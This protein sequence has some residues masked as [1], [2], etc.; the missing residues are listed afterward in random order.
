MSAT[1]IYA[2]SPV[3]QEAHFCEAREI[4]YGGTQGCGK[5]WFLRW[6][7]I[8]TQV[9]DWNGSPGEHT[10]YLEAIQRGEHYESKGWALHLRRTFPEIEQTIQKT[11]G[12]IRKFDPGADWIAKSYII[13]LSCGYRIQFGHCKEDDSW[14]AYDTNEYSHIAFDE[15]IHF[16]KEQYDGIRRRLRCEDQV[17]N[18]KRRLVSAS[19]PDA[20]AEGVWVKERFVDPAPDGRTLLRTEVDMFDGTKE[21]YLAM[22]IPASL[23]DNPDP[24]FRKQTEIDLR[25]QPFHVQQ[26]RLLG[27]WGVVEGAFFSHIWAPSVH[28][29]KPF[30]C[31]EHNLMTC[32][33][34]RMES[35]VPLSYPRGR[36][37][38]YGYKKACPVM[39]YAKNPDDDIIVYRE[40]T[41]NHKVPENK[42]KDAQM[43]ALAIKKIEQEHGEWDEKR[44]CSKL[45][46]PADYQIS[47]DQGGAGL[48]VE[49]TM[50]R[51]GVYW[52]KSVK[53]RFAATQELI[54]RLSDIP[55]RPGAFPALRVFDTCAELKRIMPLIAVDPDNPEVPKKDDN[56]HWLETLFYICMSCLPAAD[57]KS[58]RSV[59][60]DDDKDELTVARQR[61]CAHAYGQ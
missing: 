28:V 36:A 30:T 5:T 6:D 11:L 15:L 44:K 47:V 42:R 55:A 58:V 61:R 45:S 35:G 20:P 46:G 59:D 29:V 53:G 23:S 37:M 49:Q 57:K 56:G 7:P 1:A 51:E 33:E 9:Y 50:A 4:L 27:K 38:D 3:Q 52:D 60:E 18:A 31:K 34:C 26:A 40:V 16:T 32:R 48:T 14:R 21:E 25:T 10:R 54:R 19:N 41:F 43:I 13:K 24:D 17:L 8:I 2:P 39:W 12:F 22:F